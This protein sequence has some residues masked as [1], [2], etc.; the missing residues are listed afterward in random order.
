MDMSQIMVVINIRQTCSYCW[1]IEGI[2]FTA[3]LSSAIGVVDGAGR[4]RRFKTTR[5][6]RR[7]T[8]TSLTQSPKGR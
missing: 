8:S 7:A 4:G 2:V 5:Q 3:T 6:E 1:S